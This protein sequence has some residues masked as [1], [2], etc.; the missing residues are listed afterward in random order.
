MPIN[1]AAEKELIE[2]MTE[3]MKK[4][5]VK[6]KEELPEGLGFALLAFPFNE[7]GR[8]FYISNAERNDIVNVMKEWIERTEN[9][10]GKD[11]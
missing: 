7:K 4:A 3:I 5:G 8:L 10:F 11:I 1:E 6:V 9:N 2:K